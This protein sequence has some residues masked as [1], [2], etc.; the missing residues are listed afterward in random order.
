MVL[1]VEGV[2]GAWE[3]THAPVMAKSTELIWLQLMNREKSAI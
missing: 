2:Q 3:V 1:H